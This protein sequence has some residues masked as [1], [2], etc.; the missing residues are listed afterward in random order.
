MCHKSVSIKSS[1]VLKDFRRKKKFS[2]VI[3]RI[4]VLV[5]KIS[6]DFKIYISNYALIVHTKYKCIVHV[7][8]YYRK[9]DKIQ[10]DVGEKKA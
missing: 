2:P 3:K 5:K 1:P 4:L 9:N 7:H 6:L 10:K 8:V